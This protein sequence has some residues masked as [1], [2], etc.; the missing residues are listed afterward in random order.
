[1]GV[2][3]QDLLRYVWTKGRR[4]AHPGRINRRVASV[5]VLSCF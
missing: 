3:M 5:T 2:S 1:M 4:P